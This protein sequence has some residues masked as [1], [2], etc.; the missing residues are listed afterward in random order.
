MVKHTN[1][2]SIL[3]AKNDLFEFIEIWYNRKRKHSHL[4]YKTPEQFNNHNYS[5]CA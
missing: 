5:K 3:Q 1:F 2:Y 4:G